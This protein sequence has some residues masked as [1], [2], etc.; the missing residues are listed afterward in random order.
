LEDRDKDFTI[1]NLTKKE[2]KVKEDKYENQ[3]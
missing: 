2:E 3:D 1:E